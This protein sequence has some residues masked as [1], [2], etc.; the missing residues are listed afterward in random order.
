MK[1][2]ED[3]SIRPI[4]TCLLHSPW[5]ARGSAEISWMESASPTHCPLKEQRSRIT[6]FYSSTGEEWK[7]GKTSQ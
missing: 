5:D 1:F 7:V 2:G 6:Q 4:T 3:T